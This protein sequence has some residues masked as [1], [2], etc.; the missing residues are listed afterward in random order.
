[1]L[2][3]SF[4]VL[5]W[6]ERLDRTCCERLKAIQN[7]P[8]MVGMVMLMT[9]VLLGKQEFSP[10]I[11][12]STVLSRHDRKS[13]DASTMP[14]DDTSSSG[15]HGKKRNRLEPSQPRAPPQT[16]YAGTYWGGLVCGILDPFYFSTFADDFF[17]LCVFQ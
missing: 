13:F 1:M 3:T 12:S 14:A 9:M 8:T 10:H 11:S 17:L 15:G 6:Q 4:Q 2:N 5:V 16:T 7:P